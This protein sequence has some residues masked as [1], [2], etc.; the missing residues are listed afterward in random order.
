MGSK[1][2]MKGIEK[3]KAM[4]TRTSTI[5][6]LGMRTGR[7]MMMAMKMKI[8]ARRAEVGSSCLSLASVQPSSCDM[9]D[10]ET[11]ASNQAIADGLCY[12][13]ERGEH[14]RK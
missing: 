3:M 6:R 13:V 7:E 2:M 9:M 4:R 1:L 10:S 8:A 14:V 5:M 11:F 12:P